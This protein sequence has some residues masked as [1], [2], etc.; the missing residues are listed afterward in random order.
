MHG[1]GGC[2]GAEEG[3]CMDVA[4]NVLRCAEK[5]ALGLVV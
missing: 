2:M 1:C 3:G 5:D 4:L